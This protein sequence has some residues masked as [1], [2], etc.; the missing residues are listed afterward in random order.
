MNGSSARLFDR[1]VVVDWSASSRPTTGK[2]SIWFAALDDAA[3]EPVLSNP[4]TRC[5][6]EA[7]LRSMVDA[8]AS[9]TFVAIDA[10]L[11]YPAG[12]FEAMDDGSW[13]AVWRSVADLSVDDETNANNRFEVA[14]ALNRRCADSDGPFWGRPAARDLSDLA[15]TKPR[16]FTPGIAEFRHCERWLMESGLRPASCWQLMG[17]GS[18]GSQTLTLLPIVERLL[19]DLGPSRVAVWPFT[20]GWRAPSL[21]GPGVVIAETWPTA[22]DVAYPIDRI[23]DAAQVHDVVLALRAADEAGT[24]TEWFAPPVALAD[25]AEVVGAV[26]GHEGWAV[27]PTRGE[28]PRS[29]GD[30]AVKR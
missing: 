28:A 30:G 17:V 19:A 5:D 2:D 15:P 22:F 14:A 4:A 11:G 24:L 10:P 27:V 29:A 25:N 16:P 18:V 9:R 23:R 21:P 26:V 8:P 3:A 1:Y 12:S 7:L 13:R 20:S 6:A